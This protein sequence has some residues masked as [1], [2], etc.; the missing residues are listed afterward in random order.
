MAHT[1]CFLVPAPA[2]VLRTMASMENKGNASMTSMETTAVNTCNTAMASM[3]TAVTKCNASMS[4]LQTAV[5][6][7]NTTLVV[8]QTAAAGL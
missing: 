4:S 6:K 2:Q 3:E 5:T 7:C 1:C 8:R